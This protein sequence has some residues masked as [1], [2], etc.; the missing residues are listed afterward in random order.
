VLKGLGESP[1][2]VAQRP[3]GQGEC[4]SE[5]APKQHRVYLRKEV[6]SPKTTKSWVAE[7]CSRND[8]RGDMSEVGLLGKFPLISSANGEGS[9]RVNPVKDGSGSGAQ[10]DQVGEKEI[11]LSQPEVAGHAPEE[12]KFV[13]DIREIVGLSREGQEISA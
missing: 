7:R 11:S 10:V 2:R 13:W 1:A 8:D 6:S 4:G 12:L 9:R 3:K 5:A